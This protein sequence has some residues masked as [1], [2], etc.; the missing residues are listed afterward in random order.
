MQTHLEASW[1]IS[2]GEHQCRLLVKNS[3]LQI[4]G[5][6]PMEKQELEAL[7][8]CVQAEWEE[9]KMELPAGLAPFFRV[10]EQEQEQP[11]AF[12]QQGARRRWVQW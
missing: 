5:Y 9:L 12:V 7:Q 8:A 10:L 11:A 3:A 1:R 6:S 2:V 4:K